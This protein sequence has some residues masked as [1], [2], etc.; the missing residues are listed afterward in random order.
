MIFLVT[1]CLQKT[2]ANQIK[3]G[4]FYLWVKHQHKLR[5]FFTDS[6][7]VEL[8]T[9]VDTDEAGDVVHLVI[10]CTPIVLPHNFLLTLHTDTYNEN[11]TE[12]NNLLLHVI[13]LSL[14]D[15]NFLLS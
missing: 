4:D 12:N 8:P 10:G 6:N 9:T 1:E 5:M 7:S 15:F 14:K 3:P 2:V 13:L 11:Q